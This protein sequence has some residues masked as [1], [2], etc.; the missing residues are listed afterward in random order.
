MSAP[1]TIILETER[2]IIRPFA[3]AD[4]AAIHAI[5]NEAFGEV[6]HAERQEWLEWTVRNDRALARLF[7]PPYG[8]RAVVLRATGAVIGAVGLVPSLGPFDRLPALRAHSSEP[9]TGL[10]TPEVGL[11]WVLAAAHRGHGYATEAARALVAFAFAHL[12]LKRI[13]AVTEEDNTASIAVM[14]RLGMTVQRH[15]DPAPEWF[16]VVGILDN[17]A[18]RVEV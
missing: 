8:D 4:L 18:G 16:Q 13:V 6:P 10:F 12:H 17:P 5:L 14:Q 1:D 2:L 7:Q 3:L 15:P 9:S 11:F